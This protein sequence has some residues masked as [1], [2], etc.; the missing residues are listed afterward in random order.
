MGKKLSRASLQFRYTVAQSAKL[1]QAFHGAG[2][3]HSADWP[4]TLNVITDCAR[5]ALAKQALAEPRR[6]AKNPQFRPYAGEAMR[7]LTC[8]AHESE[9]LLKACKGLHPSIEVLL[10]S[11]LENQYVEPGLEAELR[12]LLRLGPTRLHLLLGALYE[13]AVRAAVSLPSMPHL[14]QRTG[15]PKQEAVHWFVLALCNIYQEATGKLPS[16]GY[17]PYRSR[18]AG[19]FY[20][21]AAAGLV[22]LALIPESSVGNFV[23]AG[24]QQYQNV[25]LG[26]SKRKVKTPR[27]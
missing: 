19:H 14:F 4:K 6:T 5:V 24:C 9:A 2:M 23:R 25:V 17:N 16:M 3:L 10:H 22:P 11:C 12:P 8:V 21:V 26:P 13:S 7:Q 20:N 27:S 15:A 1:R 18:A